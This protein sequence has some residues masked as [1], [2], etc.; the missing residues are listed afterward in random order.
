MASS[1][2][3]E[4]VYIMSKSFVK[5]ALDKAPQGLGPVLKWLYLSSEGSRLLHQISTDCEKLSEERNEISADETVCAWL[6]AGAR[7]SGG[8][9]MLLQRHLQWLREYEQGIP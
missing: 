4:N 3:S 2:Y 8:A 1:Q 6:P 9:R 7:V 5:T